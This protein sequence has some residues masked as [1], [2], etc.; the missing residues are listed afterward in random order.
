M[1]I[2][3]IISYC[4]WLACGQTTSPGSNIVQTPVP[5]EEELFRCEPITDI[6]LCTD[7]GYV[8]AT[9][10]NFRL[11]ETQTEA[12]SELRNF[13]P[14]IRLQCSGAI[15]HMLCAVYAPFCELRFP[16]VRIRPCKSLCM[17]V[18][19][20]CE[21]NLMDFSLTWPPHLECDRYPTKADDPLCFGPNDPNILVIP[22]RVLEILGRGSTTPDS[23]ST[24]Q[25]NTTGG[26]S[27]T[28]DGGT[29]LPSVSTHP[30][31]TAPPLASVCPTY[32]RVSDRIANKSFSFAGI[33]NC[34][35]N[36]SGIYFTPSERNLIAPIFVLL[37]A[38]VCVM[39]T[40]FTVATFLIDRRRFHYPE[41]PIIFLSFCYLI[42]SL[43]YIVGSI[44]KLVGGDRTSFACSTE[45]T[46]VESGHSR[47]F[48][49]Q[50]LPNDDAVYQTATCVI[51]FVMVYYFQM[52]SAIWWVVLTLTWFLAAALKWGEEAVER[53]WL[54]YHILAWSIPAIQVVLVLALRLVDGDQLSGLCYT[55]NHNI[56]GLG[57]FVFLPLTVY[58]LLGFAFLVVGFTAL[59]NIR[60]QLQHDAAK[61]RKLGRLIIRI[62]VYSLLYTVPN[63]VLLILHTYTLS[64][65]E[66]WETHYIQCRATGECSLAPSF[67]ASVLKYLMIFAIGIFSTS[68]IL[69][70]KT[71]SAWQKFFRS[72]G[73][74][75]KTYEIPVKPVHP[76]H[77]T[78]V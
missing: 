69:S 28:S 5:P 8:N 30:T 3:V 58:L 72:C 31:S 70:R 75:R 47:S 4:V 29:T 44:S 26:T 27:T 19:D 51:L 56:V 59:V 41:R 13:A 14:L 32:L 71:L 45:E 20:G 63:V 23:T 43:A 62:G 38:V 74:Q 16:N 65:Q 73:C 46:F 40:L 15:V 21:S 67:G 24:T 35:V 49:F 36:C 55:G 54:L 68:W 18:R 39:F 52:A 42:I 60:H 1:I 9:F 53:L 2:S 78:A 33:P 77:Q 6:D 10:P 25:P 7:V 11:Q 17:H 76:H 37:F 34:A 50:R 61:S 12:S 66:S 48:V 22:P 64:Q 57:V